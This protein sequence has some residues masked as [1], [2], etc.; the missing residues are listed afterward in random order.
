MSTTQAD[1]DEAI[2]TFDA[3]IA[4]AATPEQ[5]RKRRNARARAGNAA[6]RSLG[7]RRTA[8]GWE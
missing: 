7:M 2:A 8:G 5:A 3:L 1:R 4:S 6:M